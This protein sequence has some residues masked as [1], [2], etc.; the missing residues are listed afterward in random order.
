MSTTLRGLPQPH[1]GEIADA[2]LSPDA[3]VVFAEHLK[4]GDVITHDDQARVIEA[5]LAFRVEDCLVVQYRPLAELLKSKRDGIP[6]GD[7]P[8]DS[9]YLDPS[10][11]VVRNLRAG[12]RSA[13]R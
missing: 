13:G 12:E 1:P 9:M 3:A 5:V 6:I 7:L 10:R 4:P 11:T 8:V 2:I